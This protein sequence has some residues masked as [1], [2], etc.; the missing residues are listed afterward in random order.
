MVLRFLLLHLSPLS[1]ASSARDPS[2]DRDAAAALK[3]ASGGCRRRKPAIHREPTLLGK[4][5]EGVYI[6]VPANCLPHRSPWS[7][8]PIHAAAEER[9]KTKCGGSTATRER[10]R[11]EDETH[12]RRGAVSR[13]CSEFVAGV[14]EAA[15]LDARGQKAA[16]RIGV[17]SV[18]ATKKRAGDCHRRHASAKGTTQISALS[19]KV[20]R[21]RFQMFTVP[22][23]AR[24]LRCGYY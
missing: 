19:R 16:L 8:A 3:T 23:S 6:A 20:T 24:L 1:P 13:A 14:T 7:A 4:K 12:R 21:V 9:D 2:G 17:R 22:F 5:T 18:V 15:L 11:R 10:A